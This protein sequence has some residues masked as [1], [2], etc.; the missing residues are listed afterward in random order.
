MWWRDE[1]GRRKGKTIKR[2]EEENQMYEKARVMTE[3]EWDSDDDGGE[4]RKW[5]EGEEENENED[6]RVRTYIQVR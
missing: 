1:G 2:E 4:V 5:D 6:V 3:K